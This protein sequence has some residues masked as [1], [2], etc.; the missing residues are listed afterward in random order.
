MKTGSSI[1]PPAVVAAIPD[2]SG[3]AVRLAVVL[4][5]YTDQDGRCYPRTDTLMKDAGIKNWNTFSRARTELKSH[6]LLDWHQRSRRRSIEYSWTTPVPSA[7]EGP[8]EPSVGEDA[9]QR[10]P[11][12]SAGRVP[13]AAEE[14][15]PHRTAHNTTTVT[16]SIKKPTKTITFSP[17]KA[18]FIGITD[19]DIQRWRNAYPAVDVEHEIAA[20]I[21]W[22]IAN[23]SRRKSNYARFLTNWFKRGQDRVA[24][25]QI[26]GSGAP[27]AYSEAWWEQ[28][29]A[30]LEAT[31]D[32]PLKLGE[33]AEVA[34]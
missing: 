20:A 25:R 29:E 31:I 5:K 8:P 32:K 27:A 4:G 18:S 23:P 10:V 28:R 33:Y 13:S 30:H 11:S 7:S 21:E 16:D 9:Q 34:K 26:K 6:G 17:E 19:N 22:L 12:I 2:L 15:T 14:L 1:I 3:S 24:E